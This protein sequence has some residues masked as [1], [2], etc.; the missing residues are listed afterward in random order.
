MKCWREILF[1]VV[2]SNFL[3]CMGQ[4]YERI[5]ISEKAKFVTGGLPQLVLNNPFRV[6]YLKN[7]RLIMAFF[8][9]NLFYRIVSRYM[10][11]VFVGEEVFY[12]TLRYHTVGESKLTANS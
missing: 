11:G 9:Q 6:L 12:P 7:S 8:K 5:I 2:K 10:N 1:V 3:I 4:S